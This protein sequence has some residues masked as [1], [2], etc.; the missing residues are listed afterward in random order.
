MAE[1][2]YYTLSAVAQSFAAIVALNAVFVIYKFQLLR[3]Q[4]NELILTLRQLLVQKEDPHGL[5]GPRDRASDRV[6]RMT[7]NQVL[8]ECRDI[9]N[10]KGVFSDRFNE[11]LDLFDK[12]GQF[13]KDIIKWFKRTLWFNGTTIL[14]SLIFLPWKNL[15]PNFLQCII[16]GIVLL[17]SICALLVTIHAILFTL[18]IGEKG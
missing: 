8:E 16:L 4:R 7:E 17:L 12:N 5:P 10:K 2:Y 15:L 18:G 3:N 13:S 1:G 11:Q 9:V 6:V 14:L